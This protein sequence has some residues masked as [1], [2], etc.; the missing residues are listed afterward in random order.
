MCLYMGTVLGTLDVI[1]WFVLRMCVVVV[2]LWMYVS[3]YVY[4]RSCVF[5]CNV[6]I[7]IF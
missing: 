2:D 4:E 3:M 5:V 7:Y 6:E 1:F